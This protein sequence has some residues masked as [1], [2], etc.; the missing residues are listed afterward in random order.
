QKK[1]KK[2]RQPLPPLIWFQWDFFSNLK[3]KIWCSS[4]KMKPSMQINQILLLCSCLGVLGEE[5]Y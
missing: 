5:S 2:T 4:N 1:E 3:L